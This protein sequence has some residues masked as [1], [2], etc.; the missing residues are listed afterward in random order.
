[1]LN[2]ACPICRQNLIVEPQN[3]T[4]SRSI[5]CHACRSSFKPSDASQAVPKNA[6]NSKPTRAGNLAKKNRV[7]SSQ[8]L[9]IALVAAVGVIGVVL[10]TV[11]LFYF[12]SRG[13]L[14]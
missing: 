8:I 11:C 13:I 1:M 3:I 12:L 5:Q 9:V 10:V 2:I 7:A 14:S 6:L 4:T